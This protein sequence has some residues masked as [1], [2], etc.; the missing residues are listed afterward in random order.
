MLL[1]YLLSSLLLKFLSF[2]ILRHRGVY[3]GQDVAV[4]IL[5]SEH[6]NNA[7]EDEFAQEVAILRWIGLPTNDKNWVFFVVF[8]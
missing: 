8:C 3:F 2:L 5:I 7:L 4:K 6:L 1:I